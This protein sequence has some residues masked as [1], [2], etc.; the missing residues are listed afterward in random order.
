MKSKKEKKNY[1]LKIK[2]NKK[3]RDANYLFITKKNFYN[4]FNLYLNLRINYS[5]IFIK[6]TRN[7]NL[8]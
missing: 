8:T 7:S 3:Y 2:I 6:I 5:G 1:N 4:F